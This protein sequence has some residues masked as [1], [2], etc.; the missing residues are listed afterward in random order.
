MTMLYWQIGKRIVSELQN[1]DR[2]EI[3]GKE[4]VSKLCIDLTAEYGNTFAE[5]NIRRMMQFNY[6]GLNDKYSE[7]D[8]ETAII[9]ELQNFIIELVFENYIN[10]LKSVHHSH[11]RSKRDDNCTLIFFEN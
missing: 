8:L 7:K 6:L 5:K 3:Y 9:V 2:H 10:F 4:V 1:K 11:K